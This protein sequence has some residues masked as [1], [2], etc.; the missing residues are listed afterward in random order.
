M[1]F[2]LGGMDIYLYIELVFQAYLLKHQINH[3]SFFYLNI[4]IYSSIARAI[5]YKNLLKCFVYTK[6]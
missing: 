4:Y 6:Y 3:S 2:A 1:A 5:I